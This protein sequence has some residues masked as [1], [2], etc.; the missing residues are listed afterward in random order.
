M[1][2]REKPDFVQIDYSHDN[3]AVEKTIP[4]MAAEK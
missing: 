2:E 1:M 3:R 4:P